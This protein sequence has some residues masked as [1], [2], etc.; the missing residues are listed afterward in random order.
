[1]QYREAVN[2]ADVRRAL[3]YD[4]ET[5]VFRWKFR[6]DRN[7]TWNTRFAGKPA[8][9]VQKFNYDKLYLV[10]RINKVLYLGHRLA[11]LYVHGVWP[12]KDLDHEDR[13]SL[14]NRIGN[15][16]VATMSQNQFNRPKQRDN[17]SG[18]KGIHRHGQK[19]R[20]QIAA[21]G[22][23]LMESFARIEDAIEWHRKMTIMLHGE[24]RPKD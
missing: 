8:G 20:A 3:D 13:D 23:K 14:N 22:Q 24:F 11:W 1:M 17:K 10:I 7:Q 19:W 21:H 4:P 15:L 9:S 5:G 16:R 18:H 6:D 2:A 12:D